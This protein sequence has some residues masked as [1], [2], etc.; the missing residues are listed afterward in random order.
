VYIHL[1]VGPSWIYDTARD[2][3]WALSQ[4]TS[5]SHLLIGPFKIG[6]GNNYGRVQNLHAMIAEG[7]N[8]VTWRIVTGDTAEEAAEVGKSCIE[9]SLEGEDFSAYVAAEGTWSAGRAHMEYPRT[10]ALWCCLWLN[11][12]GDW[13]YE[14]LSLTGWL[15]GQ[16]R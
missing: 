9:L 2:A 6:H 14:A 5:D 16:W 7:S 13:A 3:F 4:D 1:S 11:C 10:R 15:S 12:G 8:D